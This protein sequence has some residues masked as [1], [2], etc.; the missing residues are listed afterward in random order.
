MSLPVVAVLGLGAM[1]HAFA[2]NLL[3]KASPF[4]AGTVPQNGVKIYSRTG[5]FA[6]RR[7]SRPWRRQM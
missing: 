4:T 2:S 7:R 6:M 5:L 1:G 3:K